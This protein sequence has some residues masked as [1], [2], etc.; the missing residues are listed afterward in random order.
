MV[1]TIRQ[2]QKDEKIEEIQQEIV[3]VTNPSWFTKWVGLLSIVEHLDVLPTAIT[4]KVKK[5]I[6]QQ[7][8]VNKI[9][10]TIGQLLNLA[11]DINT[12]LISF[13]N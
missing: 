9:T 8:L 7:I 13:N 11:L 3:N 4:T 12:Y 1:E 5:D 2:L 10:I 6:G